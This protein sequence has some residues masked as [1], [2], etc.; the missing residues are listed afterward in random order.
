MVIVGFEAIKSLKEKTI[1]AIVVNKVDTEGVLVH[2]N[3]Q[4]TRNLKE[5]QNEDRIISETIK[6]T[7][8]KGRRPRGCPQNREE[9]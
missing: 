5:L 4:R 3:I 1:D 8:K 9:K 6:K 2:H 7:I